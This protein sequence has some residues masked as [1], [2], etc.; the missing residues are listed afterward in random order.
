MTVP[1]GRRR[2]PAQKRS[3]EGS[4]EWNRRTAAAGSE[5]IIAYK[6][7]H[8]EGGLPTE[9]SRDGNPRRM[10]RPRSLITPLVGTTVARATRVF[11]RLRRSRAERKH[12]GDE[13]NVIP[14]ERSDEESR[15]GVSRWFRS[16]DPSSLRS[17]GM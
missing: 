14:S 12:G 15:A 6:H 10:S 7:R 16:R 4:R 5:R 17:L 2:L 3:D 9:G 13:R 1:M 8:P 11:M